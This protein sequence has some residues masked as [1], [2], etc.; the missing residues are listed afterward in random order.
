M[1]F[2]QARAGEAGE[3]PV[4]KR[5]MRSEQRGDRRTGHFDRRPV[6]ARPHRM[7]QERRSPSEAGC[8]IPRIAALTFRLQYLGYIEG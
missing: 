1:M 3:R 6:K 5:E 7:P 8:T 4:V 2:S